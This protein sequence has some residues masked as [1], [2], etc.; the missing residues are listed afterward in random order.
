MF[1][2]EASETLEIFGIKFNDLT[3]ALAAFA[4]FLIIIL[5]ILWRHHVATVRSL[6]KVLL[7]VT[8]KKDED[9][10]IVN[11]KALEAERERAEVYRKYD[12]ETKS[13]L[14]EVIIV[15]TSMNVL[16]DGV[17]VTLGAYHE[18]VEKYQEALQEAQSRTENRD[19]K[20]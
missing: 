6:N 12:R 3:S 8:T 19:E 9:L 15:Q 13:L 10:K 17:K 5:L 11:D 16:L 20:H 7:E 4:T 18:S 14:R 1:L 2:L